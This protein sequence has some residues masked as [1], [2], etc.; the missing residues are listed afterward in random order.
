MEI[1]D[2]KQKDIICPEC[3]GKM[4]LLPGSLTSI[5]VCR[6]C[7]CSADSNSNE[8]KNGEIRSKLEEESRNECLQKGKNCINSIFPKGFMKKYTKHDNILDFLKAGNILSEETEEITF[9]KFKKIM[10]YKLD[11]YIKNNTIFKNWDEMFDCASGR[12]LMI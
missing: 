8:L 5:F 1:I 2:R 7:G 12:Y 6:N 9:D 4:Y 3:E 11:Q 10:G